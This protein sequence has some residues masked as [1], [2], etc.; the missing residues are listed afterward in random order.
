MTQQTGLSEGLKR[1]VTRRSE[2]KGGEQEGG[3]WREVRG[4]KRFIDK[5]YENRKQKERKNIKNKTEMT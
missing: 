4:K 3:M 2:R 1:N 5:R